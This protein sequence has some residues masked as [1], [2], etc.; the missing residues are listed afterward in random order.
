MYQSLPPLSPLYLF[1]IMY[2]GHPSNLSPP[3]VALA[4][5][6]Y[7]NACP[8]MGNGELG[9]GHFLYYFQAARSFRNN[10]LHMSLQKKVAKALPRKSKG[11]DIEIELI[12]PNYYKK[13]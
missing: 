9:L 12:D 3:F 5:F 10:R 1:L 8:E 13:W 4:V 7:I 11:K 6:D 2:I